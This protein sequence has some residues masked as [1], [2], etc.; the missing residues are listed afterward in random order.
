MMDEA[1]SGAFCF[2]GEQR[3]F[4]APLRMH[5]ALGMNAFRKIK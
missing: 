2:E 5:S 4:R 3:G 1:P